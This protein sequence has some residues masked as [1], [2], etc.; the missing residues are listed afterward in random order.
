MLS[1]WL[2]K[3]FHQSTASARNT[4]FYSRQVDQQFLAEMKMG[5]M[6]THVIGAAVMAKFGKSRNT[7]LEC[8]L[9]R[10]TMRHS[11]D[12]SLNSLHRLSEAGSPL[13][14]LYS[15]CPSRKL[16]PQRPHGPSDHRKKVIA[17]V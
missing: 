9:L 7:K 13:T 11:P 16:F 14:R 6:I 1:P 15:L 5:N 4:G 17:E 3:N 2:R 8:G 12:F 10:K